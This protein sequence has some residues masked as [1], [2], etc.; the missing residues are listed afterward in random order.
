MVTK[1]KTGLCEIIYAVGA[2]MAAFFF[3]FFFL[4][5]RCGAE[6][7]AVGWAAEGPLSFWMWKLIVDS[8]SSVILRYKRNGCSAVELV[9]LI[10][11]L[12]LLRGRV[13]VC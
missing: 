5:R 4:C 10:L 6:V 13:D 1:F 2:V 8:W 9:H 7:E 11:R 3:F 12:R